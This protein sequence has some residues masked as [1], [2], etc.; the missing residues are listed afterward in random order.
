MKPGFA[1]DGPRDPT[2]RCSTPG[3]GAGVERIGLPRFR[4]PLGSVHTEPRRT[5]PSRLLPIRGK[6]RKTLEVGIEAPERWL[7]FGLNAQKPRVYEAFFSK[8]WVEF[9]SGRGELWLDLKSR[10]CVVVDLNS[11]IFRQGFAIFF[12]FLHHYNRPALRVCLSIWPGRFV[13]VR[14]VRK[15]S[16]LPHPTR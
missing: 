13:Q 8:V 2:G 6:N 11:L 10:L 5:N 12:R 1:G 3:R 7:G 9:L 16:K 15:A 14:Y 4:R